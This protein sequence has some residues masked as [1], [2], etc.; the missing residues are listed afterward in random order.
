MRAAPGQAEAEAAVQE[1]AEAAASAVAARR[2]NGKAMNLKRTFRHLW[3]PDWTL[4]QRFPRGALRTITEAIA[5]S[6]AQGVTR[7][8]LELRNLVQVADL[9]VMS[10]MMRFYRH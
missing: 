2:G 4:R 8:L 3:F 1:P 6:D 5:A 7:D 9:I 10:A